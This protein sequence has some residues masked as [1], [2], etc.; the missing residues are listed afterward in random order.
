MLHPPDCTSR[1]H[2]RRSGTLAVRPSPGVASA[3]TFDGVP[4]RLSDW[5]RRASPPSRP[6]P[7]SGS[8]YPASSRRAPYSTSRTCSTTA[9]TRPIR[10]TDLDPAPEIQARLKRDEHGLFAAVAQQSGQ[11]RG[12]HGRLDR[13]PRR[14]TSTLTTGRCTYWSRE[15]PGVLGQGHP[16]ATSSGSSRSPW[17]ATR[18]VLVQVDQIGGACHTGDRTSSTPTGSKPSSGWLP[19]R[20]GVTDQRTDAVKARRRLATTLACAAGALV[21]LQPGQVRVAVAG[22][23]SWTGHALGFAVRPL[24]LAELAGAVA[25][26]PP[27]AGGGPPSAPSWSPSPSARA[28]QPS[29]QAHDPHVERATAASHAWQVVYAVA[30]LLVS[31][32]GLLRPYAAGAGPRCRPATSR[33]APRGSATRRSS[34]G[35]PRP[36]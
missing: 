8:R 1:S 21:Q 19:V 11:R 31:R 32:Q 2:R 14:C 34:W 16:W 22:G 3:P 18:A 28:S 17:T 30:A 29:G 5:L 36:R 25:S 7:R 33:R 4:P 12:A 27:G 26:S 13:R 15:P 20:R 35:G 10:P 24:A 9:P 6:R 23:K